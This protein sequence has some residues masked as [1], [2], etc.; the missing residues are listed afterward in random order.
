MNAANNRRMATR[1]LATGA[2][3]TALV[4]VLQCM[5]QFIKL[6]P[7]SI[8]LVLVPIVLGA[9]TCGTKVSSWLGAVFSVVVLFT[10]AAAFLAIDIPGTIITV[11]AKGIA[12]GAAAGV[13]YHLLQKKN[14]YLAT[15]AA[16][17]VCPVVNTGIFLVGCR[18]F[19]WDTIQTWGTAMGYVSTAEYV[20][21]GLVGG[22]FLAEMAINIVL[23]PVI[24]RILNI[25]RKPKD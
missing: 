5:G 10:D 20:V 9:A 8:S 7:F 21:Y 6:G 14:R 24:V 1:A 11:L 19:F 17:V 4:V 16:A 12:C 2:I 25:V 3:L 22:N 18:L 13:V 23:C 15:L